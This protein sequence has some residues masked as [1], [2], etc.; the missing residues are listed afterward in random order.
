MGW[1]GAI[2]DIIDQRSS[3]Y[4]LEKESI[5]RNHEAVCNLS[6]TYGGDDVE[7]LVGSVSDLRAPAIAEDHRRAKSRNSWFGIRW[8]VDRD[9]GS[10]CNYLPNF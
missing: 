9:I 4:M 6:H 8:I 10:R 1:S 3:V 2:A 7:C 5:L